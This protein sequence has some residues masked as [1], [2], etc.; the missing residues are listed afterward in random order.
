[1]HTVEATAFVRGALRLSNFCV[2]DADTGAMQ[3]SDYGEDDAVAALAS[4]AG[5]AFAHSAVGGD[6][7]SLFAPV[8]EVDLRQDDGGQR[9]SR[10]RPTNAEATKRRAVRHACVPCRRSKVACEETRPCR[11]CVDRSQAQ[12]CVDHKRAA[13]NRPRKRKAALGAAAPPGTAS[14][15]PVSPP[16]MR[17]AVQPPPTPTTPAQLPAAAQHLHGV[18]SL[19]FSLPVFRHGAQGGLAIGAGHSTSAFAAVTAAAA[20]ASA[21]RAQHQHHQHQ[22]HSPAAALAAAAAA[23][24][25]SAQIAAASAPSAPAY[26]SPARHSVP[27]SWGFVPLPVGSG[28]SNGFHAAGGGAGGGIRLQRGFVPPPL[29]GRTVVPTLASNAAALQ[30]LQAGLKTIDDKSGKRVRTLAAVKNACVHCR[31]SK[32]ACDE[33]RPCRRCVNRGVSE[34]CVDAPQRTRGR[35]RVRRAPSVVAIRVADADGERSATPLSPTGTTPPA[36][37]LQSWP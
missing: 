3:S 1:M 26:A 20:E 4:L 22:Q 11:R 23:A 16:I 31:T 35:K 14:G 18:P 27:L 36:T 28:H 30:A 15:E 29:V 37:S 19:A 5:T 24:A 25:A 13:R 7:G 6:G 12:S 8:G 21:R 9:Q 10:D 17:Q 33:E 32:V 34:S 2:R